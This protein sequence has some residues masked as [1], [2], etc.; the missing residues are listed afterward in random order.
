[1][2]WSWLITCHPLQLLHASHT[3]YSYVIIVCKITA[4]FEEQKKLDKVQNT[5]LKKLPR[6]QY[7]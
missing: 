5:D 6:I 1:M 3:L 2:G 7:E 4:Q